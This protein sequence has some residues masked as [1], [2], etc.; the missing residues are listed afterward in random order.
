[1]KVDIAFNV[2]GTVNQTIALVQDE[3][4]QLTK[5]ELLEGLR[6]GSIHTPMVHIADEEIMSTEVFK[7]APDGTTV[8]VGTVVTQFFSEP[9]YEGFSLDELEED[10]LDPEES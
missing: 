4:E 10:V 8:V 3:G 1:M 7:T 6:D 2:D 9:V 5:E